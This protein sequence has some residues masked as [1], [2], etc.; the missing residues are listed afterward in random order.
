MVVRDR[1]R[2]D[3]ALRHDRQ[4]RH[5]EKPG[6]ETRQPGERMEVMVHAPTLLPVRRAGCARL[7]RACARVDGVA[8]PL[9]TETRTEPRP[10]RKGLATIPLFAPRTAPDLTSCQPR[11]PSWRPTSPPLHD[12]SL[13]FTALVA[14]AVLTRSISAAETAALSNLSVR[15]T[16]A[17]NQT[18]IVG[19]V[20]SGGA[21]NILVR[22]GGPALNKFGLSVM[23][24][25]RLAL[26]TTGATPLA[27][28]DDWPASLAATFASVG[29]F[30]FDSGSK[31]AALVQSLNG[32]FTVQATGPSG[33][34]ILVEAYDVAGGLSPHPPGPISPRATRSR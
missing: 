25:P 15:T 11:L 24:D 17:A 20:V 22:G 13:A 10:G 7:G 32:G 8:R 6:L 27:T 28:N 14:F 19:G 34:T 21:K 31:D 9:Q 26:Y 16:M 4:P 1:P 29:A 12:C 23:A 18:L 2:D 5:S 30:A 3:E 33:G